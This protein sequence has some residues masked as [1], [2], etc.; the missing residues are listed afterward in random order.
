MSCALRVLVKGEE[1]PQM[2]HVLNV[3]MRG[4]LVDDPHPLVR[5]VLAV[6]LAKLS[7]RHSVGVMAVF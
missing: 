6:G 2:P 5:P 3:L 7:F 4:R 1:L